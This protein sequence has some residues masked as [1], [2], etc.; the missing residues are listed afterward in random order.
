MQLGLDYDNDGDSDLV[1]VGEWMSVTLFKNSEGRHYLKKSIKDLENSSGWWFSI[2]KGDFDKDGDVDFIAGNLGLNYKYKTS[3]EKPF[4]VYYNDFDN[5]GYSDIVL[6]YYNEDKHYPLRGFSCSAQQVP[7]LKKE[8]KKYDL[9][10][11]LEMNQVYG[12]KNLESGLHYTAKTFASSYIENKGNGQFEISKLPYLAQFS[13][14]NDIKVSDF[15][16]DGNLDALLIGNL[17]VSEIE[18][19]R[20]DAGTGML[21]LGDGKGNF[22][23]VKGR[24]SGFFTKKDAK[25]IELLGCKNQKRILVAN[26]ND[27]LQSFRISKQ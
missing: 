5:N 26:N 14:I 18:T 7:S 24:E 8:I 15:N 19:P 27:I 13:S 2:E 9:F 25:K 11:S 12:K 10:A 6:G 22:L 20:N 4:D 16:N 3:K 23:P 17:F 1:I 21:L